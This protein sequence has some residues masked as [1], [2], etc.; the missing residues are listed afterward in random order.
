VALF[1]SAEPTQ[2]DEIPPSQVKEIGGLF[3]K[4]VL[5]GIPLIMDGEGAGE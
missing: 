2:R 1:I 4:M 5:T 3:K